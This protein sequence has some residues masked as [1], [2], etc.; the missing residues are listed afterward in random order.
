MNKRTPISDFS[1]GSLK[2][3]TQVYISED[4]NGAI[5]KL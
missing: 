2:E 5:E 4:A 1:A 3:H